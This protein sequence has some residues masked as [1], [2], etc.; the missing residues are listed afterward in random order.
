MVSI[1]SS[2]ERIERIEKH[3]GI[4][5]SKRIGKNEFIDIQDEAEQW[6][7]HLDDLKKEI[8]E[9]LSETKATQYDLERYNTLLEELKKYR[10]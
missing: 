8:K 9:L 2:E 3:L 4:D 10:K 1:Y 5:D 6:S 7:E